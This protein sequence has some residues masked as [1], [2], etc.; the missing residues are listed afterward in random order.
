MDI[1]Q[2]KRLED[3]EKENQRLKNL[4]VAAACTSRPTLVQTHVGLEPHRLV[5]AMQ[6]VRAMAM[7]VA[8]GTESRTSKPFR[9]NA[10]GLH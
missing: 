9:Y 10:K 2:A 4:V 5:P 3:L 7:A 1:S 8:N 6:L